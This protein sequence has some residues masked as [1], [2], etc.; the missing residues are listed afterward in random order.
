MKI[1]THSENREDWMAARAIHRAGRHCSADVATAN[2]IM[3]SSRT[4][5]NKGCAGA[6]GCVHSE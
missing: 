6:D 5:S 2:I 3:L 1:T 4:S